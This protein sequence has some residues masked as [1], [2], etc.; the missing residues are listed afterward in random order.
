[1][2]EFIINNNGFLYQKLADGYRLV[3]DVPIFKTRGFHNYPLILTVDGHVYDV[4]KKII[5]L[6]DREYKTL[7]IHCRYINRRCECVIMILGTDNHLYSFNY[8]GGEVSNH[9]CCHDNVLNVMTTFNQ[10][11]VIIQSR[12]NNGDIKWSAINSSGYRTCVYDQVPEL[13]DIISMEGGII[14]TENKLY[15]MSDSHLGRF[16]VIDLPSD[17][18][19]YGI[20]KSDSPVSYRLIMITPGDQELLIELYIL[21]HTLNRE[22]HYR[23][24][25][26]EFLDEAHSQSPIVSSIR[27]PD[28][29]CIVCKNGRIIKLTAN[30]DVNSTHISRCIFDQSIGLKNARNTD[31][32]DL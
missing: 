24:T 4:D 6:D 16:V 7:V 14:T 30:G 1:M 5:I 9:R 20:V 27:L 25:W 11:N 10:S 32:Q 28:G 15:I 3:D 17:N 29:D 19:F 18:L 2:N 21:S 8:D 23:S 31:D 12:D 22:Q 13:E 26:N